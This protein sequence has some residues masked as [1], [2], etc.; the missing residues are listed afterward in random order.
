MILNKSIWKTGRESQR[1]HGK[2]NIQKDSLL[3]KHLQERGLGAMGDMNV[4]ESR[5]WPVEVGTLD[6]LNLGFHI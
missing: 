3:V 6:C 1:E 2:K 4:Y 5:S